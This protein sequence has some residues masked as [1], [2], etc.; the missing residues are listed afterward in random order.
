MTPSTYF[1]LLAEFGAAHIPVTE[2]GAKYFGHD[3]KT[4]KNYARSA[5]YPFP[6]FQCGGKWMIDAAVFGEYLDKIK[7]KAI[8]EYKAAK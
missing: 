8:E 6:V 1:G 2:V 7:A 4:A 5:R 3:D